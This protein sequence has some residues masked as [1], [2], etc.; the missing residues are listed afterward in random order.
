MRAYPV[1]VMHA[2]W[3]YDYAW[4]AL[5]ANPATLVT[6]RD[7]ARAIFAHSLDA[8]RFMRGIMNGIVLRKATYL[9]ANSEYL[10]RTLTPAQQCKTRVVPNF[11][12]PVL[13]GI[14]SGDRPHASDPDGPVVVTVTNGF[15]RWKNVQRAIRA[16]DLVRRK[17]PSAQLHLVGDDMGEAGPARAYALSVG[18]MAGVKFLGRLPYVEALREMAAAT[19][20]LHP[21]LEESFGMAALEAM[22]LGTPVVG[23]RH[24][25]NIPC[26]LDGGRAG[27]LCNVRSP[28]S[29]AGAVLSLVD[30]PE[31]AAELSGCAK[32]LARE[33]FCEETAIEAYLQY[34]RDILEQQP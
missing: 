4:S 6:V 32:T 12:P 30:D 2:Q 13:D 10:Y 20:L 27:T 34:Y 28:D 1:D 5:D 8:S 25:G 22:A 15:S 7:H 33:R 3:T 21:A 29:M 17:V 11:C 24:S 9:S 31:R 19:V 18:L 23:G 26:L 16:F 14:S